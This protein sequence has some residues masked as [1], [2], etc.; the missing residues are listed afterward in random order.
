MAVRKRRRSL[1]PAAR[2]SFEKPTNVANATEVIK[3]TV[4]A[5]HEAPT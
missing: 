5:C 2:R 4:P 3:R 1:R